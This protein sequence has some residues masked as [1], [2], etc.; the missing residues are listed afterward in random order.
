[1]LQVADVLRELAAQGRQVVMTTH[2]PIL[3]NYLDAEHIR[4]VTRT[5]EAGVTATAALDS[6]V[7]N[8]LRQKVDFGELWYSIGDETLAA[9]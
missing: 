2:S 8:E 5:A 1:M 4:I 7:F 3:L 6:R 9:H